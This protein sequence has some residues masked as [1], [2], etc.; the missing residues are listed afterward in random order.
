M[1]ACTQS[2]KQSSKQASNEHS[3]MQNQN[4]TS[5]APMRRQSVRT[6]MVELQRGREMEHWRT[7]ASED[8]SV[9]GLEQPRAAQTSRTSTGAAKVTRRREQSDRGPA[10][11]RTRARG[12]ERVKG[13]IRGGPIRGGPIRGG[14]IR[15]G[16]IRGF[17]VER[18]ESRGP[19]RKE[20]SGRGVGSEGARSEGRPSRRDASRGD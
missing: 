15:G 12:S 6:P 7:G 20:R 11:P 8:L 14:P 1:K 3:C 5:R 2:S 19:S 4:K 13:P 10:R 17:R 18:F 9:P 16:P